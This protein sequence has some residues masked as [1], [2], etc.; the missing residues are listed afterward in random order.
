MHSSRNRFT[1]LPPAVKWL[2]LANC[3]VFLA[4]LLDRGPLFEWLALW[5]VGT[6]HMIMTPQGPAFV[7]RFHIWQLVTFAFLHGGLGH[8]FF[9]MFALWMFG[10]SVEAVWGSQRFLLFY[11]VCTVGAGL[12]QLAVVSWMGTITPTIG[13]SG[14]IFGVL[15]AFGM[16][17]PDQQIFLLFP[18]IPMKA[19]YFVIGYGALELFF[20]V[21][22]TE[23]GVAHFA[24]LGGM[25]FGLILL[26]YWRQRNRLYH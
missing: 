8:I 17:F 20:G 13:A 1:S 26:L 6:P 19:K 23:S 9:N 24:H 22:G 2:V 7:P 5:P 10:R 16:M 25:L 21:T 14:G 11:F 18:P 15:L 12:T 4:L 3:V